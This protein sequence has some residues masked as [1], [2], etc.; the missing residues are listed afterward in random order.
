M[1]Q[2]TTRT[3]EA[4]FKT[5]KYCPAFPGSFES[6][7][8]A[9][10]RSATSSSFTTTTSTAIPGSACTPPPV[11]HD[12]TARAIQARRQQVLDDALRRPPRALPRPRPLAP[13]LPARVWINKPRPTIETQED[14]QINPA[15]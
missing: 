10:A 14:T 5:L 4:Q 9:P 6:L 12:G 11:V 3:S 1:Y 13:K 2:T 8:E 7:G 15:A